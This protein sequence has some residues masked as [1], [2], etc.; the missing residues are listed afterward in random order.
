MALAWAGVA[1]SRLGG[2]ERPNLLF[3]IADD[4]SYP[5]MGAYGTSWVSTPGFD[6][7]A[8]EGLLFTHA[9][10][11]NS[12]C[13]PSRACILTGRNSWQ[14]KEAC[15]H[16][17]FFPPEFKSY[18]EALAEHGYFV[19]K[20]GKGWGPGVAKDAAGQLRQLAGKPF[21]QRQTTPPAK[22]MSNNDYAANF[23]DFLD[24]RPSGQPFCFWYGATE[25]H[26][27]YEF[28]VGLALGGKKLTDIDKVPGFWP[29]TDTV[30]TD[31]L[32]YAFELEHFDQHLA[33][34][35]AQLDSRGELDNTIVVVTAD[36][37]LPFPRAKGQAYDVSNRMPLAIRWGRGIKNPGRV[38][39]D[40]VSFIDFAPTFVE[41][42]GLSWE[43]TGMQP[44]AGRSLTD[45]FT[46]EQSGQVNPQRDHVLIGQERHDVGRPHDVGYPIRGIVKGD[47]LYLR[48]YETSRWPAC[49]PETGY[50]NC[51]GS[52][53]KTQILELR[54]QGLDDRFWRLAFGKR[55][56][57]ELYDVR[58]DQECLKN[59]V[60]QGGYEALTSSLR[61]QLERELQ[62]QHDPR[63]LGQGHIFDEYIYADER[64]RG[65]YE[66]YLRGENI[67]AGWV[68]ATDFEAAPLD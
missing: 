25:P 57:E 52:P 35:L 59:L 24:A 58:H 16:I 22:A 46:S 2:T 49:N 39:D 18:A 36:N 32:D 61:E 44:A 33:K 54:R 45:I 37:G 9:Y 8:Q 50:L 3:C 29:D 11:P 5:H 48:N 4:A 19:G 47:M 43:Q 67:R 51:D 34:M 30:R 62:E 23:R 7:V 66:R 53:T 40:Y 10:T 56:G 31:M 68:E 64:T 20:T 38:I 1:G 28:G 6:R 65:F 41:V 21:D 14:L 27:P 12:K 63:V 15:N 13:A 55:P 17:P 26:R 60:E 42:A